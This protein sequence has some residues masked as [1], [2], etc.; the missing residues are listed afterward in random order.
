MAAL[1]YSRAKI[2]EEKVDIAYNGLLADKAGQPSRTPVA[3]LR[4]IVKQ[5]VFTIRIDL[6]LGHG[7]CTMHASDLTEAYVTFNKG[8]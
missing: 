6:H 4:K 8:E 1:G 5:P 2:V 3:K 7:Q